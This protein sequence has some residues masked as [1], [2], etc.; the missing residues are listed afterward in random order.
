MAR[1]LAISMR[2]RG[3]SGTKELTV[4]AELFMFNPGSRAARYLIGFG[5]GKGKIGL[6]CQIT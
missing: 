2:K 1:F 5:A 3:A 4:S 6:S